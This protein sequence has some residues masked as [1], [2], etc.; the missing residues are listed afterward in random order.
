ML[1]GVNKL[2][3]NRNVKNDARYTHL[4]ELIGPSKKRI[5]DAKENAK[6][7]VADQIAA[8]RAILLGAVR[9]AKVQ[10]LSD[11][12]IGVATGFTSGP[13]KARLLA[14]A[15]GDDVLVPQAIANGVPAV[16]IEKDGW[17][18]VLVR[19]WR[20]NHDRFATDWQVTWPDGELLFTHEEDQ[21][22]LV[23]E[24]HWHV[25][26]DNMMPDEL[27]FGMRAWKPAE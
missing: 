14:E 20:T 26:P 13:A 6:K 21:W 10:G 4:Q 16:M 18:A 3:S 23:P 1:N 12:A 17:Q 22:Y 24:E 25:V 11:Y 5:A 7:L 8:E 2:V 19:M 27:F 15:F 9:W